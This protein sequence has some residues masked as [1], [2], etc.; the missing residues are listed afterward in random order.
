M[1]KS[2]WSP[3]ALEEYR[4]VERGSVRPAGRRYFDQVQVDGVVV[5]IHTFPRAVP[6]STRR[7]TA[8]SSGRTRPSRPRAERAHGSRRA[9]RR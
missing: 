2:G 9:A 3:V 7:L 5:N 1:Q 4:V 8:R 6:K